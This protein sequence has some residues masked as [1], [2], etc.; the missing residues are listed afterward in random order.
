MADKY[1]CFSWN[2]NGWAPKAA[3]KDL[4]GW[5]LLNFGKLKVSYLS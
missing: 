3:R 4:D 5:L 2:G 1:Y